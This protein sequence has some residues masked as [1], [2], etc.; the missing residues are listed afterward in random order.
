MY[1]G[2]GSSVIRFPWFDSS[3]QMAIN[4]TKIDA[5]GNLCEKMK[6]YK[7]IEC[8]ILIFSSLAMHRSSLKHKLYN[9]KM[10]VA[11][12]VTTDQ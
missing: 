9:T 11:L 6:A 3:F 7:N 2:S 1:L 12:T 5:C 4:A 10:S 8:L